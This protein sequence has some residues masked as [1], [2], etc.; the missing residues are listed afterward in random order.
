M[1]QVALRDSRPDVG[2]SGD[3]LSEL[4]FSSGLGPQNAAFQPGQCIVNTSSQSD[5]E[6]KEGKEISNS[7]ETLDSEEKYSKNQVGIYSRLALAPNETV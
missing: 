5:H 1:L 7:Q 2:W 6:I 3:N 4:H